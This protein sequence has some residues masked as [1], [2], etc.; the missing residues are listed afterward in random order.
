MIRLF[1]IGHSGKTAEQFFTLLENNGVQGIIDTRL[2]TSS[3]LSAFAKGHD[4]EYF[5]HKIGSITYRHRIEFAPTK[6][7]LSQ[8]RNHEISWNGYEEKYLRLL[9]E[10]N[11]TDS[12]NMFR[13]NNQ[14]LLC[15][16]HSPEKCHRR[17]LAEYFQSV[18]A[19]IEIIH[20]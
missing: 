16:E 12:T 7:L 13:L 20:L 2:N 15:S 9:D 8:Y 1:T 4:L 17:V 5:L 18:N 10:R 3:Q 11:I 6:E 14:C 19:E